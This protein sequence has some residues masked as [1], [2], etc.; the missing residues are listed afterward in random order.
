[1]RSCLKKYFRYLQLVENHPTSCD[2]YFGIAWKIS[3]TLLKKWNGYP[4]LLVRAK[5]NIWPLLEI[6]A[7]KLIHTTT[8]SNHFRNVYIK[9][10]KFAC[11]FEL[12]DSRARTSAVDSSRRWRFNYLSYTR[13]RLRGLGTARSWI[14]KTLPTQITPADWLTSSILSLQ[15]GSR[16]TTVPHGTA[17]YDLQYEE[18][19]ECE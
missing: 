13:A 10:P 7:T 17:R 11:T 16:C 5:L 12:N 9:F 18:F 3:H 4:C 2:S 1:M 6:L 8:P 19:S 14:F 15:P